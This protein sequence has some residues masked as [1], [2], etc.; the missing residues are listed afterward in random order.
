MG[1]PT[2]V[3]E[4]GTYVFA[5]TAA[6]IV[7][8]A[9]SMCNLRPTDLT[10][11]HH[12]DA[13]IAANLVMGD[14][15]NQNPHRFTME[16]QTVPLIQGTA[17]Y[18]LA[19]RTIVVPIVTIAITTGGTTIERVLGP[20]SAYEY[21]AQPTKA[22]QAPPTS[23]FF[24]LAATPTL[25]FWPVPDASSTYTANVQSFRQLQDVDFTNSQGVDAP[26]RFLG[27]FTAGLAAELAECYAPAKADKFR[28]LYEG[29]MLRGQGRDQE[30]TNMSITPALGSY[31]REQ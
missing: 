21:Q 10:A 29:R 25:T 30:T 8:F 14:I 1:V 19:A 22:L 20:I 31:Y 12:I 9:W 17:T 24:N 2:N 15:S 7:L 18:N 4:T 6:D 16:L 5:P 23:Y 26:Y 13:G 27:A 28:A 3:G 11:Q